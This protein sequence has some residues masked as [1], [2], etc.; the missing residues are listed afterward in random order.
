MKK[1]LGDKTNGAGKRIGKKVTP[2]TR[3][4]GAQRERTRGKQG[5]TSGAQGRKERTVSERGKVRPWGAPQG[6]VERKKKKN[7]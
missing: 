1:M 3:S 5:R 6:G 4:C 7:N 2:T